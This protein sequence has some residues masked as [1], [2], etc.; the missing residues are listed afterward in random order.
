MN[1]EMYRDKILKLK[2]DDLILRAQLIEKKELNNGYN[3]V[4][5]KMHKRNA[6]ILN[7][8][9]DEIGYP[10]IAKVGEA[11][12]DA[13]WLIIQHA[14]GQPAFMRKCLSLLEEAVN[15]E[16]ANPMNLAY[17]SDR[18]ATFEGKPQLYGT[19]YDWDDDG[20]LSPNPYDDMENVNERRKSLGLN[21]LEEQTQ[22]M[23]DR[24]IEENL[25]PPSDILER[26]KRYD[27]WRKNV[28][29]I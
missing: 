14:I 13:A 2:E 10:T 29:W 6:K 16:E 20:R 27:E 1:L 9:I 3:P 15:Q 24:S 12:S 4:M 28:G 8:I 25:L 11:A 17:L 21:S 5:E 26:K 19:A 7:D 23:R 18:I 22:L